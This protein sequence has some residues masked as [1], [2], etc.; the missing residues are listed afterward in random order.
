M[1][2]PVFDASVKGYVKV[3]G[4]EELVFFEDGH[5][6]KPKHLVRQGGEE[7]AE[8]RV[9]VLKQGGVDLPLAPDPPRL[10]SLHERGAEGADVRRRLRSAVDDAIEEIGPVTHDSGYDKDYHHITT[11]KPFIVNIYD[12]F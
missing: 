1:Q 11:L 8:Q 9:L 2:D 4:N 5:R 12:K 3:C 7:A 6:R 10:P